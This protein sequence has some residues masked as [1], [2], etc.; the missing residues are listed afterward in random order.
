MCINIFC[1]LSF[2][3]D[4]ILSIL[5]GKGIDINFEMSLDNGKI[6]ASHMYTFVGHILE[7]SS[8]FGLMC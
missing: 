7:L 2:R 3:L 1:I 5:Y 8:L 6:S 4:V